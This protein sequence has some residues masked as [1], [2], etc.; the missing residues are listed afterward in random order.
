M[1]TG[2]YYRPSL[3]IRFWD[4]VKAG[5]GG[6]LEWTGAK[7]GGYGRIDRRYVHRIAWEWERGPIPPGLQIDHLCRNRA[8]VNWHH[9]E[10]VTQAENKRR[11]EGGQKTGAMQRAKTHCPKGHRYD[12]SNTYLW[13]GR[14]YEKR[15]CRECKR[16]DSSNRRKERNHGL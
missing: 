6:C 13:V 4:K 14:L 9:M 3:W 11:G 12:E 7:S 1:P 5:H 10:P 15:Q 2:V 8:C 16:I